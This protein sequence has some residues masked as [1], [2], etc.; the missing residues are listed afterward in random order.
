MFGDK[1]LAWDT[2]S[3]ISFL[4]DDVTPD[5]EGIYTCVGDNGYGAM[6]TSLYLAVKCKQAND[7]QPVPL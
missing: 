1:E 4:L 5:N 6:N 2:A 7:S 3:N